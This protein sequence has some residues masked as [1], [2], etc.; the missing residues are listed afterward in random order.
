MCSNRAG[1]GC[2]IGP[3]RRIPQCPFPVCFLA[4]M[5]YTVG[6]RT[7][8]QAVMNSIV[9]KNGHCLSDTQQESYQ[10]QQDEYQI[11]KT[12]N[13]EQTVISFIYMYCSKAKLSG[14]LVF[15]Y[16]STSIDDT[17]CKLQSETSNDV[18]LQTRTKHLDDIDSI[19][20]EV[21]S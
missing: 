2:G 11:K 5:F 7:L 1:Y 17:I 16:G 15:G 4:R 13:N 19:H 10:G 9:E 12:K 14:L 3:V 8:S 21:N 6:K 18:T 20:Y